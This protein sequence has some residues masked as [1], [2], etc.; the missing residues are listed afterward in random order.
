VL[1]CKRDCSFTSAPQSGRANATFETAN[2]A[3]PSTLV[4]RWQH[5][6][7]PAPGA[8]LHF[9]SCSFLALV[10]A[11]QAAATPKAPVFTLN[12]YSSGHF[13]NSASVD[14]HVTNT[15]SSRPA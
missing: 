8:I 15:P 5:A 12:G 7:S 6:L 4:T 2:V 3:P 14:V 13:T 1:L 10:L 9:A 11:A